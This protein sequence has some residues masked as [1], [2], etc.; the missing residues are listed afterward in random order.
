MR[1]LLVGATG[2]IGRA[3]VA[4]L[5]P[6]HEIVAAGRSSG[7]RQVDITNVQSVRE[8]YAAVGK[9]DAVACA[10]GSVHFGPLEAMT[11]ELFEVGLRDK[12]M[13]QVNLVL[14]GRDVVAPGG[15]FTLI[16]G[17]LSH[18]P[19]RFG[20]SA[21]MVN[22]AVDSFVRAAAVEL[23][24]R[25]N[26]V[27]PTVLVESMDAYGDYFHGFEAVPAR[28]VALAFSKSIEGSQTGQ[29]YRVH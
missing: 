27:S 11:P 26:A 18:D 19:I 3:V 9:V 28:R 1:I 23:P 16:S 2:T 15:S 20:T 24:Q 13:G 7:D 10:A 8:L 17:I 12:L 4:E 29:I 5:S 21:S 14:A 6:R 25:I 22:G